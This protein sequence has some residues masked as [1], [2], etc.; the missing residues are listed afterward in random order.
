MQRLG[1]LVLV[2]LAWALVVT[3]AQIT[4][5][6]YFPAAEIHDAAAK[7]EREVRHEDATPA[8]A[9]PQAVPPA[10]KP[11]SQ[12]HWPPVWH[13]RFA[14]G[15]P[16][17]M[18]QD[19]NINVTTPAIRQ[20]VA[21]RKKR[22]PHLMPLFDKGALGENNR[23][24]VEVRDLDKL[25]LQE[26][27]RVKTLVQQENSDR[28]RLYR[29]LAEANNITPDRVSDIATIFAGVNRQE[30]QTGWWIQQANGTW[31]NKR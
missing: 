4:V 2:V 19:I 8:E 10:G 15:V 11:Q 24:F 29:A 5:N 21:E 30:A 20:L 22:F 9:A 23:G 12:Y 17:A 25:S 18:A 3:C 28:A 14:R 26:Q 1:Q 27:G 6:I 16:P 13:I 31:E 7:I